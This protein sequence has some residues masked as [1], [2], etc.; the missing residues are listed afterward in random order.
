VFTPEINYAMNKNL[1][2][3]H[4]IELARRAYELSRQGEGPNTIG[5]YLGVHWRTA[6]AL[7]NAGRELVAGSGRVCPG[8]ELVAGSGRVCPGRELVAG[9][10]RVCPGRERGLVEVD[11]ISFMFEAFIFG[12]HAYE[13][14]THTFPQEVHAAVWA[15]QRRQLTAFGPGF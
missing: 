6:D 11:G 13:E 15:E 8:R 9:S 14:R 10:G 2:K 3:K 12:T 5:I 7:I 1:I 4:G